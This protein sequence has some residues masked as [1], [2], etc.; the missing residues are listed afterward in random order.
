MAKAVMRSFTGTH[1]FLLSFWAAKTSGF[2]RC[3]HRLSCMLCSWGRHSE[4]L[5]SLASSRAFDER[6]QLV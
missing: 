5:I 4:L 2:L 3:K 1:A 6:L